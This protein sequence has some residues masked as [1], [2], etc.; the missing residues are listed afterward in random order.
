MVRIT[1]GLNEI[2]VSQRES[3]RIGTRYKE[4]TTFR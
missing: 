1:G 3:G 2:K 4:D